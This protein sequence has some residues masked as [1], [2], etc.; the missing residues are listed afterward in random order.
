ML[1]KL[2]HKFFAHFHGS[3]LIYNTCWEDPLIDRQLLDL[4]PESRVVAI[5]SAGCNVLDYLLDEPAA[6][7]AVDVNFRQ[8]ALLCLKMALLAYT[9]YQALFALFGRGGWPAYR[10]T[11]ALVR[12]QLPLWARSFWDT[13]IDYFSSRGLRPSFYWRGGAGLFAWFFHTLLVKKSPLKRQVRQLLRAGSL[14]EQRELYD[15]VEAHVFR[16]A[17]TWTLSRPATMACIGVPTPQLQL[18]ESQYAGGLVSFIRDSLRRVFTT[19]PLQNNYFWRVYLTGSYTAACCPGYLKAGNFSELGE[20]LDRVKV[21]NATITR[22]LEENPGEYSHYVLLDHQDWLAWHDPAALKEEWDLIFQNSRPGTRVLMRSAGLALD[23]LA[24][25]VVSRVRFF[26]HLTQP[27]HQTDR[28]GTYGS[29]HLA[30][31]V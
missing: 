31:V 23:F 14:E 19:V 4:T 3:R 12:R 20:R 24:P 27:L 15:Q 13:K 10:E 21:H 6:I 7:H 8:N 22:F 9:D 5:T 11:Y 29:L 28:V 17:V 1:T 25:E 16:R 26:P 2:Q 18:I 30:E